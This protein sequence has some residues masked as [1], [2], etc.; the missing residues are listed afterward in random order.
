MKKS[1]IK[2]VFVN[3]QRLSAF[4]RVIFTLTVIPLF[5][6]GIVSFFYEPE[7]FGQVAAWLM[8]IVV[9]GTF[10]C[11]KNIMDVID[12]IVMSVDDKDAEEG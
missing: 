9:I 6:L 12:V 10:Q 11:V 8:V 1:E 5:I 7:W 2:K 4:W 3:Y